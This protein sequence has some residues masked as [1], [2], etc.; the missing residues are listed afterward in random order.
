MIQVIENAGQEIP[1][2]IVACGQE[3][4]PA[5]LIVDPTQGSARARASVEDEIRAGYKKGS[6]IIFVGNHVLP[7]GRI[8]SVG[9][10][11]DPLIGQLR[12]K[13]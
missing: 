13:G 10:T 2:E 3:G 6:N 1:A 5:Y 4:A 12:L 11:V 7:D 9:K 8:V